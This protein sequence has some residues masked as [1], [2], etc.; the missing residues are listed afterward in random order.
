MHRGSDCTKTE[1]IQEEGVFRGVY[2]VVLGQQTA[3]LTAHFLISSKFYHR[4][5][6]SFYGGTDSHVLI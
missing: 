1:F 6:L 4:S 2:C 3:S 5:Q